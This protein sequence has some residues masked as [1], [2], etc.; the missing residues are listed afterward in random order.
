VDPGLAGRPPGVELPGLL[1]GPHRPGQADEGVGVGGLV[2]DQSPTDRVQQPP[3]LAFVPEAFGGLGPEDDRDADVAEAFGQ[4]D[5]LVGAALDGRE[6]I[7]DQ[8]HVIAHPGLLPRGEMPQVFQ[9]EAD[10]GIGVAAAGDGRDGQHGQVHVLQP[11]AAVGRAGQGAEEGRVAAPDPGQDGRVGGQL[12]QIRLAGWMAAPELL[13]LLVVQA[14][15]EVAAVAGW[16]GGWG[17][18]ELE[19]QGG[20]APVVDA[21][22]F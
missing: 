11:P 5:G 18:G 22:P 10:G 16:P 17:A 7:Q 2:Q 15:Q 1:G 20:H 12:L 21:A 9:D 8:Q 13:E 6:L 14:A 3:L 4:V 19:G